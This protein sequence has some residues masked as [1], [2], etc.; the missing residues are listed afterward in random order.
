MKIDIEKQK[1]KHKSYKDN[2][3]SEVKVENLISAQEKTN[4]KSSVLENLNI[5]ANIKNEKEVSNLKILT[6]IEEVR[7]FMDYTE[8]CLHLIKTINV[9]PESE[10]EDLKIDLPEYMTKSKKLAIFDLDETLVHCELKNPN[11]A[12]NIIAIKLPNGK[13]AKVSR[14]NIKM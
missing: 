14:Y 9:P 3:I 13:K 5:K 4:K 11:S 1:E 8:N 12:D 10:I 2:F 7:D 6:N